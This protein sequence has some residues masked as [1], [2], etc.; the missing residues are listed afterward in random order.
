MAKS[1]P[2]QRFRLMVTMAILSLCCLVSIELA[3]AAGRFGL[4]ALQ[5]YFLTA[6][7][8]NP[9]LLTLDIN[10]TLLVHIPWTL[11]FPLYR[12][13]SWSAYREQVVL[14][15]KNGKAD[16]LLLIDINGQKQRWLVQ[17]GRANRYPV[18]SPDGQ[19]IVYVAQ[20]QSDAYLYRMDALSGESQLLAQLAGYARQ[21]TWSP[22]GQRLMLETWHDKQS[23]LHLFDLGGR[24]LQHLNQADSSDSHPS[25]SPDSQQIVFSSSRD[26][27]DD[28][29]VMDVGRGNRRRLTADGSRDMSPVWSPDGA[30]I[31]FVS[32][33]G[34]RGRGIY[35]MDAQ[36]NHQR[37]LPIVGGRNYAPA[38]SQ[39]GKHIVFMV[40]I[41]NGDVVS[42]YLYLVDADGTNLRQLG[43]GSVEVGFPIWSIP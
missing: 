26:G 29:Y 4:P 30:Q 35:V 7:V 15:V 40:D 2:A 3:R 32:N 14:S 36:G 33:R 38:W 8:N 21:A 12:V 10:R 1:L 39:D 17:D 5:I 41:A 22:D 24:T 34:E 43:D 16:D 28:L 27:D 37:R 25:W 20:Q 42:S 11:T 6:R 9:G 31:A 18:W 13:E 19:W 23:Q